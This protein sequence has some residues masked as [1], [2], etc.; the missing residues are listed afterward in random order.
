[1]APRG[2]PSTIASRGARPVGRH[3][4]ILASGRSPSVVTRAAFGFMQFR[5]FFA[6][7]IVVRTGVVVKST[8]ALAVAR[9]GLGIGYTGFDVKDCSVGDCDPR[10]K[11]PQ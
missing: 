10:A 4:R 7:H 2:K 1:M 8:W 11:F 3:S 6:I 5:L 9:A